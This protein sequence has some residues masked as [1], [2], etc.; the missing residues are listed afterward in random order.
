MTHDRRATRFPEC[1]IRVE[2]RSR[3]RTH[4]GTTRRTSRYPAAFRPPDGTKS[5]MSMRR[6]SAGTASSVTFDAGV[7]ATIYTREHQSAL[8][9]VRFPLPSP[10]R[11]TR[12]A[13][14]LTRGRRTRS[15]RQVTIACARRW[16]R[17]E[18]PRSIRFGSAERSKQTSV[19]LPKSRAR[20]DGSTNASLRIRS[21]TFSARASGQLAAER[22]AGLHE[23]ARGDARGPSAVALART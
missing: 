17:P 9:F 23:K 3:S 15:R 14:I 20:A 8:P 16:R 5:R 19:P 10:S 18:P 1:V 12:A 2:R 13:M 22:R 7:T 21:V 4:R 11:R 6:K